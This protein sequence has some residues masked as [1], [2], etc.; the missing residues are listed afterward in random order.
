MV[1]PPQ[2]YACPLINKRPADGE[3]LSS[4]WPDNRPSAGLQVRHALTAIDLRRAEPVAV[5]ELAIWSA[6]TYRGDILPS[7][8]VTLGHILFMP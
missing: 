5:S 6:R 1:A 8:H 3:A 7:A 2:L 4:R